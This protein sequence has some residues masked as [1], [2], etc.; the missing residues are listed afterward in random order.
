MNLVQITK[1]AKKARGVF[2][3]YST[4]I[5]ENYFG[6]FPKGAC[7]NASS[8]LGYWLGLENLEYVSGE[9]DG[10]ISH[11]WL[12]INGYI[13]DITGDQFDA[14]YLP[15]YVSKDRTFHDSFE[16][17]RRYSTSGPPTLTEELNKFIRYMRHA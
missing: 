15:V 3:R 8:F 2:D 12:E 13:I 16:D 14:E 17:Q 1:E 10:G 9:R 7:G 11:A 6:S 4:E 5:S